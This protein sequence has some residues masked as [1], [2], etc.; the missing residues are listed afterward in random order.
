MYIH[1]NKNDENKAYVGISKNTKKRW[2]NGE[3]YK[4]QVKF[5]YAIK[6]HGWDSFKHIILK[7]N[8]TLE[9]AWEFEKHYIKLYD[10]IN[11]G[12]NVHEGGQMVITPE[13]IKKGYITKLVKN[14]PVS[15]ICEAT[16]EKIEFET[17]AEASQKTG[18]SEG[19]FY[20]LSKNEVNEPK[21][22]EITLGN[23]P[24]HRFKLGEDLEDKIRRA[25]E[26]SEKQR[27]LIKQTEEK[28]I[29]KDRRK[30]HR[31]AV[32][33]AREIVYGKK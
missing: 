1:I 18:I 25:S 6:K 11:D 31:K 19:W 32:K 29:E 26:E 21:G 27:L 24:R 12:Y 13:M 15:I 22:Y 3:G 7:E 5:Y 33:L 14:S 30:R 23:T 9:E 17:V 4:G 28:A 2:R 20:L 10:S 16:S 8:L